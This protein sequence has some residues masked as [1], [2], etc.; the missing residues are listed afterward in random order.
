MLAVQA[1]GEAGV[2][3]DRVSAREH[4]HRQRFLQRLAGVE[5]LEPRQFVVAPAQ[6]KG[7]AVEDAAAFGAGHRRPNGEPVAGR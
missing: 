3:G 5:D 7:G 1:G 2:V 4:V 6:Q